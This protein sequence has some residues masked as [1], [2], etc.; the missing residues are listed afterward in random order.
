M[1]YNT[2]NITVGTKLKQQGI[3]WIVMD[4]DGNRLLLRQ[5]GTTHRVTSSLYF[6]NKR[7]KSKR[8]IIM[9]DIEN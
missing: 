4:V 2:Y 6:L 3:C 5:A 9:S 1:I 8:V 7:I